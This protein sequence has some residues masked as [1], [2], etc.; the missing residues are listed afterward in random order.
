[1]RQ[2]LVGHARG[3]QVGLG[4]L[5]SAGRTARRN[6]NALLIT[7]VCHTGLSSGRHISSTTTN[8]SQ[9]TALH[10]SFRSRRTR[11]KLLSNGKSNIP[12][13]TTSLAA[14]DFSS[15]P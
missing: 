12:L 9:E 13:P 15:I 2:W 6:G 3:L 1:M 7:R 5:H 11:A 4:M 8:A 14:L 10:R